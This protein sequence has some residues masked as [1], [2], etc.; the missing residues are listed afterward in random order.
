MCQRE[1]PY[2]A[3]FMTQFIK[4]IIIERILQRRFGPKDLRQFEKINLVAHAPEKNDTLALGCT[5]LGSGTSHCP[6][7]YWL[8]GSVCA[9]FS[10]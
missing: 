2:T 9:R 1:M 5:K 10:Q 4:V 8:A 3:N 7:S 6:G